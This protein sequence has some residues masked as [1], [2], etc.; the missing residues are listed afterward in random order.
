MD[1]PDVQ[2]MVEPVVESRQRWL[3][4]LLEAAPD[5]RVLDLG[6]GTGSS[7]RFLAPALPAGM[8]V[9]VDRS[10]GALRAAAA[11]AGTAGRVSLLAVDLERPL[12]FADGSFDR[13][14]CHNVLEAVPD[15]QRLLRE[16]YRVLRPGG[17]LVLS[18]SDYDTLVF[19]SEDVALTRR[20][21]WAY[22]DTQQDWMAAVDGTLGRHLV[23]LVGRSPFEVAD[24][25]VAVVV[26]RD[27][28]P[29]G[30]GHGYAHNLV[31]VLRGAGL[32]AAD[33][34][35][36]LDGLRRLDERGAFLFSLNDY[37]VVCSRPVSGQPRA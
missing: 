9:G 7:L 28:R 24:V 14:L 5:G 12:P 6:C 3:V 37:A 16:A 23:D 32:P 26:D 27:F 2:A 31:Q 10:V 18:H 29:G 13:A 33:L 19:A 25:R 4:G 1:E 15:R 36:W 17:R 22:S 34:D 30:L 35:R 8:A 11:A 21:V 20:L